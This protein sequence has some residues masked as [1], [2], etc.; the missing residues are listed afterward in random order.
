[1]EPGAVLVFFVLSC[2][3]WRLP[4]QYRRVGPITTRGACRDFTSGAGALVLAVTLAALVPRVVAGD[5]SWWINAHAANMTLGMVA[6]D[7]ALLF[8]ASLLDSPLWSL[9]WEVTFSLLVPLY[10][11]IA[12]GWRGGTWLK[13]VAALLLVGIGSK[14]GHAALPQA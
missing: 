2:S 9:R 7:A 4:S 5:Q 1:M 8:N 13:I 14:T 12:V 6:R 11:W 3:R 10:V